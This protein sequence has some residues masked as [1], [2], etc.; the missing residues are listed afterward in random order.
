MRP[1]WFGIGL[2]LCLI[3]SAVGWSVWKRRQEARLQLLLAD[4]R[5]EMAQGRYALARTALIDLLD[6]RPRWDEAAY[7]LGV[8]E[9]ARKR[10]LAAIE[11]WAQIPETSSLSGWAQVRRSRIEMDR[12]R[13]VDCEALLRSAAGRL[14]PHRAEA[15]WGLVLLLR[16]EGRF[17]EAK[18][19]LED[20][21]DVMTDPV[22]TLQRLYK[23][24]AD[25][26]PTE[27]VSQALDRA[28]RQAPDDDRVWLGRAHL[29]IR[30]G[31]FDEAKSWL[32]RCLARRPDDPVV[33]RMRLDWA[34]A[35]DRPA[36]VRE[37]LAHLPAG[38]EPE[39]RVWALRA[40]LAERR[41]DSVRELEA[42][43]RQLA[44]NPADAIALERSAE[45]ERETGN[46]TAAESLRRRKTELDEVRKSYARLISVAHPLEHAAELSELAGR[47]G[48]AFDARRWAALGSQAGTAGPIETPEP[49]RSAEPLSSP[50]ATLADL[51]P[52]PGQ[53]GAALTASGVENKT[54][55]LHF[56]D[57]AESAEL[58]FVHEN[59][60][61]AENR[62]IPPIT[63]SGGVG[64]LDFDNDGWLDVY[65]VQG[66]PFPPGSSAS[67][68]AG[69]RLYRNRGDGTFE[70]VTA[71]SGIAAMARGYGHG[72]A[73]GDID[74][75]GFADLFVTRWRSYAL[76]RNRG[77]GTFE[78]VTAKAGFAGDRDW[79]TS[80]A[81][82]DLDG[83]GD[84]DLYV[85]HYMKWNEG[86]NRVCSDPADP[87]I[88]HCS[89][90]DFEALADHVFRN[91]GGKFVDVTA[92][93]GIADREGRG[94]GVVAADLDQ[95]GGS[96]S[97]WPTICRRITC[98]GTAAASGSRRWDWRQAWPAMPRGD[99]R[100]GWVS[101][102]PILTAMAFPTWP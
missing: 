67:R 3:S 26:F 55:V 6:R 10:P 72:V 41:G 60:A 9:A 102:A 12:G 21:F 96:I 100:R 76:Y 81:F 80:A 4:A 44:A 64:L 24:D 30:L 78:D 63:S 34:L 65:V 31:R 75:D 29:A 25:P 32:D 51:L 22:L 17:D 59:G 50:G 14:G 97:S 16:L 39:H 73:V 1:R 85:C 33:W 61:G 53:T 88:Y 87:T 45:L 93:A 90:L 37:A 77:D 83:D 23:L 47:L 101:R 48:R 8:C 36:E 38:A 28:G 5:K 27:G 95:D 15:R 18:R 94:L 74:N 98:S 58:R 56:S 69:D 91:D 79:P 62:L 71:R 35:A 49:A 89:P 2:A 68:R 84:L 54:A 20:G 70:D 46:A 66:G 19:W 52:E 11:A 99:L 43:R 86:D 92:E 42:L 82:A 40:W 13:W 7:E 57:D